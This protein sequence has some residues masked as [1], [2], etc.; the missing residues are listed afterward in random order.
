MLGNKPIV[1]IN[2]GA[3]WPKTIAVSPDRCFIA[4]ETVVETMN[5]DHGMPGN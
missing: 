2:R 3:F 4:T 5:S 1:A